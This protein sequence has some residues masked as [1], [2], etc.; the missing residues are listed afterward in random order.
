VYAI[1]EIPE[2]AKVVLTLLIWVGPATQ[3]CLSRLRSE[4]P[5]LRFR[6]TISQLMM[7]VMVNRPIQRRSPPFVKRIDFSTRCN[8]TSDSTHVRKAHCDVQRRLLTRIARIDSA[9][10]C[11]LP[12]FSADFSRQSREHVAERPQRLR[13]IVATL[14]KAESVL[15]RR[16]NPPE[17]AKREIPVSAKL[18]SERST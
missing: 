12:L 6:R 18:Q 2:Q 7:I 16:F 14:P 13:P 1:Y 3:Q 11:R 4:P 17:N 15:Y 9:C 8:Q 5:H 10:E